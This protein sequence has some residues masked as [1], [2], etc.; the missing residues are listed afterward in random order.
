MSN[1]IVRHKGRWRKRKYAER[2]QKFL[3]FCNNYRKKIKGEQQHF[4]VTSASSRIIE[5]LSDFGNQL[6]CFKCDAVLSLVDTINETRQG[7]LM[8]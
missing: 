1:E 7:M 8:L 6:I 2:E 3:K 5:S 4:E